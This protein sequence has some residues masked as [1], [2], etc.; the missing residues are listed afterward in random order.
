MLNGG[1]GIEKM[2]F[3]MILLKPFLKAFKAY[4]RPPLGGAATWQS[5][6]YEASRNHAQFLCSFPILSLFV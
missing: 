1:A 6:K 5:K 4:C 3:L 2:A